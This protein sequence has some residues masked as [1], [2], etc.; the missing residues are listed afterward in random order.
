MFDV[1]VACK[2]KENPS[3]VGAWSRTLVVETPRE[4]G[5]SGNK[6]G[7]PTTTLLAAIALAFR[8]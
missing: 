4:G 1:R 3:K 7:V 5:S 2:D 8:L 6:L